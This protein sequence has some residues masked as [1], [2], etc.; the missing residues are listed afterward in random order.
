MYRTLLYIF[1]AIAV[2]LGLLIGVFNAQ[3][4]ELDLF[5]IKLDW[6]LGLLI[7]LA[8]VGGL[9]AGILALYV[10]RVWPLRMTIR[11]L[12]KTVPP[13]PP[14]VSR[15]EQKIFDSDV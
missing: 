5:W 11:K 6:P 14:A 10:V 9:L 13:A 12:Q 15:Q 8:F 4:V 1:A 2:I 3:R 7:V